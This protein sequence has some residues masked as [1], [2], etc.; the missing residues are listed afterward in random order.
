MSALTDAGKA[1]KEAYDA[2][3]GGD[4]EKGLTIAHQTKESGRQFGIVSVTVSGKSDLVTKAHALIAPNGVVAIA[5][6]DKCRFHTVTTKVEPHGKEGE[7]SKII[8][9]IHPVTTY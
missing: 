2:L 3:L 4:K 8:T 5:E 1:I 9:I 6:P 7:D